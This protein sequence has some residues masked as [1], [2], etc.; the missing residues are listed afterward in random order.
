MGY[1]VQQKATSLFYLM[2]EY[3]TNDK[4]QNKQAV[5]FRVDVKEYNI[6]KQYAD[7][8]YNAH[9]QDHATKQNC[10]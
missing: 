1:V 10:R 5:G 9:I 2:T 6:L 8:F 3:V 4:N 7:I